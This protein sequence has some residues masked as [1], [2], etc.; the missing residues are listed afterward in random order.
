MATQAARHQFFR[1]GELAALTGVSKDT[2][3]YYERVGL[4]GPPERASNGYRRYSVASLTRVR[5]I[6][7][8]LA[9]GFS[10]E[11]LAGILA[12]RKRGDPP[13]RKVR[14]LAASKLADIE[15]ALSELTAA[16]DQLRDLLTDWDELLAG[17]AVSEC[18]GL[19]E[20]LAKSGRIEQTRPQFSIAGGRKANRR[21]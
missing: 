8:A 2:L 15:R 11:E 12:M 6:R 19:L 14:Q 10:V 18:A 1:S 20:S 7:S 17:T 13:C 16:R 9:V 3:R 5:L 4:L 21:T